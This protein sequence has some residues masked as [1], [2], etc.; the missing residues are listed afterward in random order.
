MHRHKLMHTITCACLCVPC[1]YIHIIR[2]N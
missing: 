1:C 2:T